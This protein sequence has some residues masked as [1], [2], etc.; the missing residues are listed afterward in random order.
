MIKPDVKAKITLTGREFVCSGYRPAHLLN[1]YLT[2][3]LHQYIDC[4]YLQKGQE[5][6]GTITFISPEYYP[7]S[8]KEGMKISFQE[9]SKIT[10]FAEILEIYNDVLKA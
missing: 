3:G 7:H 6:E 10:G 1:G 5:I 9:G 8:I 2:T 4:E